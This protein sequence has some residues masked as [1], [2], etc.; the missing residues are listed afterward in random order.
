MLHDNCDC[1]EGFYI[2]TVNLDITKPGY[3]ENLDIAMLFFWCPEF[4]LVKFPGY[5]ESLDITKKS[6]CTVSFVISG[7]TVYLHYIEPIL[8]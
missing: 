2:Y 1:V 4:C 3:N 6:V 8:L 7:F 5:N